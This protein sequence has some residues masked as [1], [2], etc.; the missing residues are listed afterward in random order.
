MPAKKLILSPEVKSRLRQAVLGEI[1]RASGSPLLLDYKPKIAVKSAVIKSNLK[2]MPAKSS[3]KKILPIKAPLQPA[4]AKADRIIPLFS[5]SQAKSRPKVRKPFVSAKRDWEKRQPEESLEKLFKN[6][7]KNKTAGSFDSFYKQPE[8]IRRQGSRRFLWLEISGVI[9]L[10]VALL[11]VYVFLGIYKYGLNDAF[12]Y[13]T[14]K[15][16]NL[17]AGY[18]G[19]SS[20][21]VTDYLD[22]YKLLAQPLAQNR[23]GLVDYS[24]KTGI[25]DKIF[26]LLAADKLI[27]AKLI[28]YNK[29]VTRQDIDNQV[30]SL[31]KQ[32]GG[33]AQAEKIIKNLYG[34]GF[35]QF[36]DLVLAPMMQRSN[37][38]VAI[39]NDNSLP[40]T[41]AA[42]SRA[43]EV[44]KLALA[45]S[46]DFNA[47]AKQYSDDEASVNLGGDLGWVVK[48]QLD[49]SWEN[50]IFSAPAGSIVSQPIKSGFGFHIVKVE[51]KLIDKTTGAQSVKLRHILIKV[52][53][54]QYITDLLNSARVV[55]Y[56][57]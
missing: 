49:Q 3:V 34:L 35:D 16:L 57:N 52:D 38:Q 10:L 36:R 17:P 1:S 2:Y 46:T 6:N 13:Q 43:N 54:D 32:T 45:S 48:G 19:D 33:T 5:V 15:A 47:L 55:K 8:K 11:A 14:A 41:Q 7:G 12:S 37:L 27:S 31:L 42:A 30:S 9:I 39:I 53:V 44:L 51:Q 26:Y 23:E 29:P 28:A 24:G 22:N 56:I 18:V 40:I 4:V 50:V 21:S 20:I 25:S